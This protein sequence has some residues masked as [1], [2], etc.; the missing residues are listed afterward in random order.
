MCRVV[1][2]GLLQPLDGGIAVLVEFLEEVVRVPDAVIE[3]ARER[4][5]NAVDTANGK[6]SFHQEK[7]CSTHTTGPPATIEPS[8]AP[9]FCQPVTRVSSS[10]ASMYAKPA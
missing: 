5:A 6:K 10:A 2:G 8:K 3:V 1:L 7:S 4:V 9:Q